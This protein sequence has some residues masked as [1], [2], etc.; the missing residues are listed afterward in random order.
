L[1]TGRATPLF[2][3][4]AYSDGSNSCSSLATALNLAEIGRVVGRASSLLKIGDF[5]EKFEIENRAAM[6]VARELGL[7]S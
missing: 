6:Q 3:A 7:V 1:F 2:S 5:D 4:S